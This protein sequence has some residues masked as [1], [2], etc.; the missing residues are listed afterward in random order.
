MNRLCDQRDLKALALLLPAYLGD[1]G[2][3]EDKVRLLTAA[4]MPHASRSL[5][6]DEQRMVQDVIAAVTAG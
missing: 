2:T 1:L 4:G 6:E 3:D 5:P